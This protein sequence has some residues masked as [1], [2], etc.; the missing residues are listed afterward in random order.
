MEGYAMTFPPADHPVWKLLRLA[1]VGVIFIAGANLAYKNPASKA[2]VLPLLSLLLGVG[3]F[4]QLKKQL[5]SNDEKR[6]DP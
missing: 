6:G 1:L 5:T 2:D 3:G 4:D